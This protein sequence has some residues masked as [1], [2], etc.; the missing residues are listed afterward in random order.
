MAGHLPKKGVLRVVDFGCG[1]SYLTFALY[2]LLSRILKRDVKILGLDRNREVVAECARLSRKL[3]FR[4]LEFRTGDIAEQNIE[5]TVDLAVSLHACDTAT[6][7][8]LRGQSPGTRPS[9]WRCPAAS[10]SW[11][12]GST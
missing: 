4:G 1:K 2:H 7:D 8:A 3:D 12:P 5:G 6:D 9:F 11:R 10:T